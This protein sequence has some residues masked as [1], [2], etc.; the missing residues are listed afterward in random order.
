MK[1]NSVPIEAASIA[2]LRCQIF[3]AIEEFTGVPVVGSV[4]SEQVG[5]NKA[6]YG[7]LSSK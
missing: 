4:G 1:F 5:A 2:V 3:V 7:Y 6:E